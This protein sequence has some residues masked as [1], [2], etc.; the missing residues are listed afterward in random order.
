MA[1]KSFFRERTVAGIR[2]LQK[3]QAQ[4]RETPTQKEL[5]NKSRQEETRQD[6]QEKIKSF[7]ETSRAETEEFIRKLEEAEARSQQFASSIQAK[8]AAMLQ[9]FAEIEKQALEF[10][11]SNHIDPVSVTMQEMMRI[12]EEQRVQALENLQD[13]ATLEEQLE[14]GRILER[15]RD[16]AKGTK[17]NPKDKKH[18]DDPKDHDLSSKTKK[19]HSPYLQIKKIGSLANKALPY[20]KIS[21]PDIKKIAKYFKI[22]STDSHQQI[23]G[24]IKNIVPLPTVVPNTKIAPDTVLASITADSITCPIID[25]TSGRLSTI[26]QKIFVDFLESQAAGS[27][28]YQPTVIEANDFDPEDLR[29]IIKLL[30]KK[31][32]KPFIKLQ[33]PPL[34]E[35][36][37]AN[38]IR[39]QQHV[40]DNLKY[41]IDRYSEHSK[42]VKIFERTKE[43]AIEIEKNGFMPPDD[44]H[45][46]S[47]DSLSDLQ[48]DIKDEIQNTLNFRLVEKDT[49]SAAKDLLHKSKS[50]PLI[51]NMANSYAVG[52]GVEVGSISQEE[53]ILRC[54]NYHVSLYKNGVPISHNS[55]RLRYNIPTENGNLKS[56]PHDAAYYTRNIT[57]LRDGKTYE[58][59]PPQ[60]YFNIDAV[61]IAGYNLGSYSLEKS[62][63]IT[64]TKD[65]QDLLEAFQQDIKDKNTDYDNLKKLFIEKTTT[66]IMLM[67]QIAYHTKAENLVLGAISCGAF[68]LNIAGLSDDWTAKAV[69]QAYINAFAQAKADGLL[70]HVKNIAF[71]VMPSAVKDAISDINIKIFGELAK[72]LQ[73]TINPRPERRVNF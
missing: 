13:E 72:E 44:S 10:A 9:H 6:W 28:E 59:L 66:K 27:I 37:D 33:L 26:Q 38:G 2:N 65:D 43:I 15:H 12:I 8:T 50:K 24:E 14:I 36:K 62:S 11:S 47:S 19:S 53:S 35:T 61:A 17:G 21:D 45:L 3:S 34:M 67:L 73:K 31:N 68:R 71:A 5:A 64:H 40:Y 41:D 48:E 54:S 63:Y 7:S 42:M 69:K 60:D 46:I 1:K 52:G 55:T 32:P 25:T 18:E 70:S 39:Y 16:A 30:S 49:L 23:I 51:M 56:I 22:K 58:E 57:V 29:S 20:L 4:A